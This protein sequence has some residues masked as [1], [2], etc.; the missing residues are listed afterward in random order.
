MAAGKPVISTNLKETAKVLK[1]FNCGLV[2]RDWKEFELHIERL[3]YDRE[4]AKKL[5]E[6]GRKA[7]DKYLNNE[8]LA[9]GLLKNVLKTFNIEHRS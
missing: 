1:M 7:A 5:G 6:N 2:A 4:L 9:E 3:Y 8:L